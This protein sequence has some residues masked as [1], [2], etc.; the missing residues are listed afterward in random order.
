MGNAST[1]IKKP[2]Y[3]HNRD[4]LKLSPGVTF[5]IS[6]SGSIRDKLV[7]DLIDLAINKGIKKQYY[8][9]INE[10]QKIPNNYHN[11]TLCDK[12]GI[13]RNDIDVGNYTPRLLITEVDDHYTDDDDFE[14]DDITH[15][16]I[17]SVTHGGDEH[18]FII[19]IM[20]FDTFVEIDPRDLYL[21][22]EYINIY[23]SIE[24]ANKHKI[25]ADKESKQSLYLILPEDDLYIYIYK[26]YY[27][28]IIIHLT[29]N[30]TS[31][32]VVNFLE[33]TY[34]ID[35][36]SSNG[37]LE[38]LS[39]LL[40]NPQ[41]K[42]SHLAFD[43]ACKN[44][45]LH[46]VE[47]WL[48]SDREL[49]YS[50]DAVDFAS[51]NGYIEIL[52]L[53]KRH[54]M[55]LSM[56][57]ENGHVEVLPLLKKHNMAKFIFNYTE[58]GFDYALINKHEKVIEFW[59]DSKLPL[60]FSEDQLIN[61]AYSSGQTYILDVLKKIDRFTFTY[62]IKYLKNAAIYNH[63][64]ILS[65]FNEYYH[66]DFF[67]SFN[68]DKNK[69]IESACEYG[70]IDFIKQYIALK[71]PYQLTSD[72]LGCAIVSKCKDT[73]DFIL[74]L[75]KEQNLHFI[76]DN[77]Y[78]ESIIKLNCYHELNKVNHAGIKTVF[79]IKDLN[80]AITYGHLFLVKLL[81]KIHPEIFTRHMKK[82][83]E[84]A[85]EMGQFHIIKWFML[86]ERTRYKRLYLMILKY[87][88]SPD[89]I[90]KEICEYANEGFD[91]SGYHLRL[92]RYIEKLK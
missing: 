32:S 47:R 50:T 82:G 69:L 84:T 25:F 46:I 1:T 60:K 66:D 73:L 92:K 15:D 17:N 85:Y 90:N 27:K 58:R 13:V 34:E 63:P 51:E 6:E 4:K 29:N 72:L 21:N 86:K 31:I 64:Q 30:Y 78:Y 61:Y 37:D 91:L 48:N 5:I 33:Q 36:A 55:Y 56:A 41:N 9:K 7:N 26:Y 57:S 79:T 38:T 35:T 45:H 71:L 20:T 28:R 77:N 19:I 65:W 39:I 74:D 3:K 22:L 10:E 42:Y 62:E 80:L 18:L 81:Y 49:K 40:E 11:L 87:H 44:G 70:S 88:R 12:K 76:L 23:V 16:A 24:Y 68:K 52:Q 2:S 67:S 53:L 8:T 43:N 14:F 75:I 54:D 83:I 59:I 89:D